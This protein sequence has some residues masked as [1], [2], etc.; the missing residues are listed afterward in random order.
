MF[1]EI[2][3]LPV[4]GGLGWDDQERSLPDDLYRRIPPALQLATILLEGARPFFVKVMFRWYRAYTVEPRLWAILLANSEL[5]LKH[6]QNCLVLPHFR[7]RIY[8]Y[9]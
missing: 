3:Y 4:F 9:T 2:D 6:F 7:R 1:D 8:R 5:Q